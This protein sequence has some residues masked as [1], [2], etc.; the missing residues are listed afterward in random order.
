LHPPTAA[1]GLSGKKRKAERLQNILQ[2]TRVRQ[3]IVVYPE[4]NIYLLRDS[5]HSLLMPLP[6]AFCPDE[7]Y[8]MPGVPGERSKIGNRVIA[9]DRRIALVVNHDHKVRVSLIKQRGH[10]NSEIGRTVS[11]RYSD[12]YFFIRFYG[13]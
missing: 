6:A 10:Q 7:P 13:P 5:F 2:E 8:F 9:L 11:C 3:H 1:R 4:N 12:R